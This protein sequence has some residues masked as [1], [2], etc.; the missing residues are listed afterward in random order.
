MTAS[1]DARKALE[2]VTPGPW[3]AESGHEQQN[4]QLYWQVTDGRDAIVQNQYCWCQGD[5]AANARFIAWCREG[6]PALLADLAAKDAAIAALAPMLRDMISRGKACD[7]IRA[8]PAVEVGVKPLEW[9]NV[10]TGYGPETYEAC[11]ATGF[12]QVFTDEDSCGAVFVEFATNRKQFGTTEARDIARV[13]GFMEAKAAAQADYAARIRSALT[14][15]PAPD[16]GK[17]QALVEALE[18]INVGEGWAAK[19]ARAALAAMK[20]G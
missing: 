10:P 12:Y 16:A 2:G 4:G 14:I 13:Y 1:D 7:I 18:K 5:H 3:Q 9:E 6:V 8:L 17:V 20:E 11:A 15:A 19:I